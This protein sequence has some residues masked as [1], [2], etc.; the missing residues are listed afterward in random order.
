ML[1]IISFPIAVTIW[2]G[3]RWYIG[4]PLAVSSVLTLVLAG[5]AGLLIPSPEDPD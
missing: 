2:Q 3:G 1:E 4:V 5:R